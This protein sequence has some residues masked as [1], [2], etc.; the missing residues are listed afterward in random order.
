MS[1]STKDNFSKQ[2]ELYKKFRPS[3]PSYFLKEIVNL[4]KSKDFLWDAGSGNGQVA[5]ALAGNFKTIFAT[6]IS[7][8][9]IQNA[10]QKENIIYSVQKAEETNFDSNFFDLI[11]V[12]Q[13]IHWFDFDAFYKEALRVGKKE[14]ILAVWGYGLLRIS[15]KIDAFIDDFYT[16]II[17][18]YWDTERKHIDN[19]YESIPFPFENIPLKQAYF[20]ESEWTIDELEGYLYTWSSVQ[21]YL[22][23]HLESPIDKLMDNIRL[24]WTEGSKMPV[25]FPI[26]T[27]IAR[28]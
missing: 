4:T 26:F 10:V 1:K 22:D 8:K 5:A 7:T 2:S 13:A 11:T 27:K 24:H 19:A 18:I 20:I 16:T 6:D 12:A 15:P 23:K 17:G 28:L 21:K 9:Q 25:R 14:A 3:Y